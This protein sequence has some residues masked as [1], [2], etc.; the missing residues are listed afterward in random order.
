MNALKK[1]KRL[2]LNM[3]CSKILNRNEMTSKNS[4][5]TYGCKKTNLEQNL[6]RMNQ[7]LLDMDYYLAVMDSM[8]EWV[9]YKLKEYL[10][11]N[12]KPDQ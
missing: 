6:E 9:E 4:S 1:A 8:D 10:E 2:E 11:E 12:K 5:F 3:F 7:V